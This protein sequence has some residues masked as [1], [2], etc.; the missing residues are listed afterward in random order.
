L[1]RSNLTRCTT[2][3]SIV[4]YL[5]T[6]GD[7]ILGMHILEEQLTWRMTAG[8]VLIVVS[9]VVA[10]RVP[11]NKIAIGGHAKSPSIP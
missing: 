5:F 11:R 7:M 8:A 4:T 1:A 3:A 6:L 9:L 2:R 10:N